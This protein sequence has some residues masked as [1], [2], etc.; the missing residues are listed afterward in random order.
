MKT[1]EIS[2]KS[3]FLSRVIFHW[4]FIK[5]PY[6]NVMKIYKISLG[7]P[8]EAFHRLNINSFSLDFHGQNLQ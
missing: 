1:N 8:N 5:L 7:P 3:S 4:V 6:E 2:M